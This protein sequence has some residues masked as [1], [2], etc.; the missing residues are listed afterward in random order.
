VTATLP[1]SV[2]ASPTSVTDM[3]EALHAL[4]QSL[5]RDRLHEYLLGLA[6]EDLD[7]PAVVLLY[8]L[9]TRGAE[10]RMSDVADKLHVDAATVTRKA[11]QLERAGLVERARDPQDGRAFRL[12]LTDA[13]QRAIDAVLAARRQWLGELLA[14]WTTTDRTDLTRLL[15][16]FAD[17][18]DRHL[19]LLDG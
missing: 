3:E 15:R 13:G 19:E 4:L 12:A 7:R 6:G 1:G 18:V 17:T 16:Q 10:L 5:R 8:A 9:H 2:P 11:Q 14:E